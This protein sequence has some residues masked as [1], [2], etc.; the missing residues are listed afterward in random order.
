MILIIELGLYTVQA[1]RLNVLLY[2]AY[3]WLY[4]SITVQAHRL[5]VLLYAAYVWLY[6]SI[7]VQAHRLNVLLYAAYVWLYPSITVQAQRLN[8]LLY[9][10]YVWLYPSITVQAQTLN[11]YI[12]PVG[13]S[14]DC[15][16][17]WGPFVRLALF[18]LVMLCAEW[19]TFETGVVLTGMALNNVTIKN[20]KIYKI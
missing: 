4:P 19:W 5:N 17:S 9:A 16:L 3:V 11:I 2:A 13:W 10:A 12:V 14:T 8:V 20:N 1:Q 6:P 15:L 7:T 18:A